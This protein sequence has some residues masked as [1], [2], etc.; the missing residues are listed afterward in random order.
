MNP[1]LYTPAAGGEAAIHTAGVAVNGL[2][3]TGE[4]EIRKAIPAARAAALAVKNRSEST[5]WQVGEF[6]GLPI[7]L[8]Q[9]WLYEKNRG[10]R[11]TDGTLCVLWCVEFP[12]ARSDYA[13]NNAYIRSTRR[14][15]NNGKH[16][17]PAPAERC[18]GY[19]RWGDPIEPVRGLRVLPMRAPVRA[20]RQMLERRPTSRRPPPCQ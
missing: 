19:D 1:H 13:K 11:F 8:Y 3:P 15:Y 10:W 14:D 20:I 5:T 2:N 4:A 17:A 12:H 16:Q 6:T 7:A 18:V 9:N